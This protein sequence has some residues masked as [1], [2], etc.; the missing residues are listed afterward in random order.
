M[1]Y[2]GLF[3]LTQLILCE[4]STPLVPFYRRARGGS[5]RLRVH[6]HQ[7]AELGLEPRL[8]GTVSI[9]VSAPSALQMGPRLREGQGLP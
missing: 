9:L 7:G 6:S 3:I 5:E 2:H 4:V 1:L 8:T